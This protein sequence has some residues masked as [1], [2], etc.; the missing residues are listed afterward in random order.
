MNFLA[1][2]HRKKSLQRLKK[3]G[4]H[5]YIHESVFL[6]NESNISISDYV[7]IQPN[8]Q[9]YAEGEEII[10]GTGTIFAHDI[11]IFTRN[12]IY[13][14]VDLK[15]LPYDNRYDCKKV[16]IGKYVWIAAHV[17]IMPGVTIGDGAVIAAGS[18]VSK[19]V[20][21]GAVVAGNP[22]K[23]IKYRNMDVYNRLD[24]I[25]AGYLEKYKKY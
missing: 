15:Y 25:G 9:L 19:D 16:I 6:G 18:V 7:H 24:E 4:E 14:A 5:A 13:D 11:Q 2:Y 8:C 23:I 22:A 1:K 10:I 17:L 21:K 3:Y 20:P 12:H